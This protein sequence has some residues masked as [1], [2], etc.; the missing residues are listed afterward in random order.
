MS[1]LRMGT[2]ERAF[3]L[4]D[5]GEFRS[6]QEI[7]NRLAKEGLTDVD[8]HLTGGAIRRDLRKVMDAAVAEAEAKGEAG[9]EANAQPDEGSAQ[10]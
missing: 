6:I 2:V 10:A 9:G 8:R 1:G 4:A 7:R 3:D 5:S